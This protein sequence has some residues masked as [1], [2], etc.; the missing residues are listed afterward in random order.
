MVTYNPGRLHRVFAPLTGTLPLFTVNFG[1]YSENDTQIMSIVINR[2]TTG[3]NVGHNPSTCEVTTKGRKDGFL[4]GSVLRVVMPTGVANTLANYLGGIGG[5]DILSRY[6]G[7]LASIGIDDTGKRFTTDVAG[8]SYLTQMNYSPVHF[9][10]I[11]G[12]SIVTLL[13]NMTQADEP[14]R[15]ITFTSQVGV[16]NFVQHK[17]LD[18]MLYKDGIGPYAQ[19]IGIQL[20]ERRDGSTRAWSHIARQD[21]ATSRISTQ[22]PLMRSQAIAPGRYEQANERPAKRVEYTIVNSAGGT[23]TRTAEIANP[24]GE[25]IET[26]KI[27]WT[28]WQVTALD[29]QLNFEAYA[30][31]YESSARLYTLPTVKIDLLLLI[32]QGTEYSKRIARQILMLEVG[33]PVYLSGDWPQRLRGV[34]FADG[35]KETIGPDEWSFELSLIPHAAAVGASSPDVPAKAWD[36]A[37]NAWDEE[38]H[39]WNEV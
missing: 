39:E 1:A 28:N 20:Q 14:L 26:E 32:R 12:Q 22:W 21:F 24:T 7:R 17:T 36:S 6:R 3:R 8:S 31:V 16:T 2:G 4:T 30:R 25:I 13:R 27:D 29:N 10:P 23:A 34:H 37:I 33:E 18:P 11:A 9:T 19:D 38:T 5:A 15:G 35:I